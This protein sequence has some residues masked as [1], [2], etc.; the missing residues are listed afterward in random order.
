MASTSNEIVRR[1]EI[2]KHLVVDTHKLRSHRV[3]SRIS[4]I[5]SGG[6]FTERLAEL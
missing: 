6:G 2:L 4:Q 3:K 1:E 5:D